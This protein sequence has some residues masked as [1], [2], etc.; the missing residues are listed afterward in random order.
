MNE[1]IQN[2]ILDRLQELKDRQDLI[3]YLIQALFLKLGIKKDELDSIVDT[4][5]KIKLGELD[6]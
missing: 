3:M 5:N 4:I 2:E 1:E 6:E